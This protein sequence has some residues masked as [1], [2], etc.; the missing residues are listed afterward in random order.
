ERDRAARDAVAGTLGAEPGE[1]ALTNSTT[2]GLGLFYTGLRLEPGDEIV[3]TEHDFYATH[4]SLRLRAARTGA[5]IR[6]IRLYDDPARASVDRIVTAIDEAVGS[7]TR[8]VAVTWVHSGTG[9][10]LPIREIAD[11]LDGRAMVCVDGVHGFAAEDADVGQLGCDVLISGCHKWLFGPRGTGF[12][13]AKPAAWRRFTAVVPTFDAD[14]RGPGPLA[15][16]GGYQAYEHRWA[17]PAAAEFHAAIGRERIAARVHELAAL[18][19]DGLSGLD[20]LRLVTPRTPELSSGI[21]CCAFG[22]IAAGEA[23]T[24]L[25]EAGVIASAT[26][27]ATPYLRFGTSIVTDE[28]DV[29]KAVQAVRAL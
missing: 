21:V 24:R 7:R 15:S 2:H 29:A 5:K 3:T 12:I 18:L 6:R 19:K 8:A 10:K 20:G 14:R 28:D 13:W 11:A 25:R 17:L 4:E 9:V 27:Y 1:V 26:P 22:D 23:V 16:P